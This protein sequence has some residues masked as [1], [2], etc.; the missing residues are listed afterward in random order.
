MVGGHYSY[1]SA[2]PMQKRGAI[3]YREGVLMAIPVQGSFNVE[4]LNE[5]IQH[6]ILPLLPN[7]CY[8]VA[9]NAN[10]HNE[11]GLAAILNAKNITLVMLPTYSYDLNPIEM[12]FGLVKALVRKT[13]VKIQE[14]LLKTMNDH[15]SLA[16]SMPLVAV[17]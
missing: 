5:V 9:D 10:V 13:P 7:N 17:L 15:S 4:L 3:G 14:A 8:L 1:G 2:Y 6:Q 16:M 12:V 11:A